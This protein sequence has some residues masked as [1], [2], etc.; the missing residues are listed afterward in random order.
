MAFLPGGNILVTERPGRLRVVAPDG[1]MS[2]PLAGLPEIGAVAVQGLHDLLLDKDFARTRGFYF[3]YFAPPRDGHKVSVDEYRAWVDRPAG[4]HQIGEVGV[5]RIAHARLSPDLT[6]IEDVR[7]IYEGADYRLAWGPDGKLYVTMADPALGTSKTDEEPQHPDSPYGKVLRLNPDGSIPKDNPFVGRP[8]YNPALYDLGQRDIQGAAF[9]PRTGQLWTSEHGPRG[10]DEI[11]I[12]RPGRNYGYP[13]ISYGREYSG[14]LLNGGKSAQDGMEQPIY[15]WTP[16]I[17][18][19][20]ITFYTGAMFPS[21]RNSLFV[22]AQPGQRLTRLELR[23]DRVVAEEPILVDHC[24]RVR[25]VAEGPDGAL[26]ALTEEDNG[27][28]IRIFARPK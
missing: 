14:R 10:G 4:Q 26:Y 24:K 11:N 3:T 2:V 23:G 15:F 19:S 17:G 22:S 5:P 6:R 18:P 1:T 28:L 21:W 16:S 8:G 12:I 27:E 9:N 7:T 20:G 25:D 13:V